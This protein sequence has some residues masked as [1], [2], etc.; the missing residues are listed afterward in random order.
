MEHMDILL[1]DDNPEDRSLASHYLNREFDVDIEHVVDKQEF[2]EAMERGGFDIVITDYRL[3]WTDGLEVLKEIKSRYPDTGVIMFTGTGNEEIA[4]KAIQMG[5]DDYIIKSPGHFE[6]IPSSIKSILEK[7]DELKK[8]KK[9]EK[10]EELMHSLLRHDVKNKIQ[11]I[12][13]NIDLIKEMD[14]PEEMKPHL[15]TLEKAV[16]ESIGIVRKVKKLRELEEKEIGPI[17]ITKVLNEVV[18]AKRS[19]AEEKYMT[20]DH[21][22]NDISCKVKGSPLISE[23][24][25]NLIENS[26]KHSDGSVVRVTEKEKEN[27]VVCTIEDDGKGVSDDIKDKIFERGFNYGPN[28]GSGLGMFLAKQIVENYGGSIEVDDSELGGAKFEVVLKKV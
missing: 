26:I 8:R 25:G 4:V 6:L 13:G 18:D 5:L 15:S 14:L 19:F 27:E 12:K 11:V 23:L 9:A 21:E 22:S 10:R 16:E 20:I 1:I 28:A 3:R 7:E 17:N 24:Y 2:G